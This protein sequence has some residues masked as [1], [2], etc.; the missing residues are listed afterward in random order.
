MMPQEDFRSSLTFYR[1]TTNVRLVHDRPKSAS[2]KIA[3][4]ATQTL[5]LGRLRKYRDRYGFCEF[6]AQNLERFTYDR[7]LLLEEDEDKGCYRRLGTCRLGSLMQRSRKADF[8][9]IRA[10]EELQWVTLV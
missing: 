6:R 2:I 4:C 8:V 9:K 10:A 1:D 5:M 7:A 3:M